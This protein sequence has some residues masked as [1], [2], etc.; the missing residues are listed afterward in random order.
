[1]QDDK[2]DTALE[3]AKKATVVFPNDAKFYG[4]L[5]DIYLKKWDLDLAKEAA[6]SW[7]EKDPKDVGVVFYEW[8]I[9]KKEQ[10]YNKAFLSFRRV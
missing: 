6:I 10:E 5:I 2:I 7:K 9:F 1:M 8:L 3:Y 4:Y